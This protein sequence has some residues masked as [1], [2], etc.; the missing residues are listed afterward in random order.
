MKTHACFRAC[1]ERQYRGKACQEFHVN[2]RINADLSDSMHCSHRTERECERSVRSERYY[3][4][5]GN[6]IHCVEDAAIVF[7][8]HKVDVF[9]SNHLDGTT[10]CRISENG[11]SLLCE[12]H[13]QNAPNS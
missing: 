10:N 1:R 5:L 12:L 11:G 9:A 4:L 2:D 6:D 3:I 7:E 8:Y 13:E